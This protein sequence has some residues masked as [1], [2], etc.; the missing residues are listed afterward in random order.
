MTVRNNQGA[1]DAHQIHPDPAVRALIAQAEKRGAVEALREA[2][3]HLHEA[4]ILRRE[5]LT[6]SRWLRDQPL[7]VPEGGANDA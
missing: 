7:P 4:P 2:A 6:L 1:D 5:E 3:A